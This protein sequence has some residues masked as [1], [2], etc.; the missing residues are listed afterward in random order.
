MFCI[1]EQNGAYLGLYMRYNVQA[2]KNY[3]CFI[4]S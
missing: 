1:D 4:I 3:K 2:E